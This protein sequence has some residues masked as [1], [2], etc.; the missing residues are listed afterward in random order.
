MGERITKIKDTF[1]LKLNEG[2]NVSRLLERP[3]NQDKKVEEHCLHSMFHV[4]H[5][6]NHYPA[7]DWQTV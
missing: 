4:K 6:H 3:R 2:V 7:L 5:L 1:M